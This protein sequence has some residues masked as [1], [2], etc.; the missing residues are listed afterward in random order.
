MKWITAKINNPLYK[1]SGKLQ[2]YENKINLVTLASD[3]PSHQTKDKPDIVVVT[4]LENVLSSHW[5][6][7][8]P[9]IFERGSR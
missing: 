6:L 3:T 9:A 7:K 4:R 2:L 1:K 5:S 8:P